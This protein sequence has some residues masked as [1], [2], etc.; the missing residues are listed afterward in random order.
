MIGQGKLADQYLGEKKAFGE[1]LEGNPQF[2]ADQFGSY[3]Y[4]LKDNRKIF[5]LKRK[6]H[7]SAC[8]DLIL[9]PKNI[10]ALLLKSSGESVV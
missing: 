6:C 8:I 10:D 1:F 3:S 4:K 5:M 7:N 2:K 9:S